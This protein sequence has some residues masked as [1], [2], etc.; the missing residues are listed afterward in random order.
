M[1]TPYTFSTP[2]HIH[3]LSI[4]SISVFSSPVGQF[5]SANQ[6]S[7]SF[8]LCLSVSLSLSVYNSVQS[9]LSLFSYFSPSLSIVCRS[10]YS[11]CNSIC[12]SVRQL[13][14]S[15]QSV[16]ILFVTLLPLQSVCLSICL[17]VTSICLSVRHLN[18]SLYLSVNTICPLPFYL[19]VCLYD[20]S[21]SVQSVSLT[22][23]CLSVYIVSIIF[24]SFY[25]LI[26][27]NTLS[28]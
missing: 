27:N 14:L 20:L 11:F 28:Y 19:F 23:T 12:L 17:S 7:P 2:V 3:R 13:S 26:L 8:S 9:H 16:S 10:T 25:D 15:L 24:F 4:N 22:I 1:D 5:C 6:V 21:Q 18:S